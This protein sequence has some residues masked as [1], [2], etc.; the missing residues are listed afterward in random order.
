MSR[1]WPSKITFHFHV[2]RIKGKH[3]FLFPFFRNQN[4]DRVFYFLFVLLFCPDVIEYIWF[5]YCDTFR[6]RCL[7]IG[8]PFKTDDTVIRIDVKKIPV[9]PQNRGRISS[10]RTSSNC[11][12]TSILCFK[13]KNSN[14][15]GIYTL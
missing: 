11:H 13:S 6:R 14:L 2:L 15:F 4:T 3:F 7:V 10:L 5:Y 8:R 9:S 1:A 12:I